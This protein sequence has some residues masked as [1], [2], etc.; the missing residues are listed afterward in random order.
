[1]AAKDSN[2]R[3]PAL[4]QGMT[5]FDWSDVQLFL[6]IAHVGSLRGASQ[7]A[8]LSV[9]SMRR[10]LQQLEKQ[11]GGRLFVRSTSGVQ[12]TEAGERLMAAS[13]NMRAG[14]LDVAG[15]ISRTKLDRT[16][17]MVIGVCEGLAS[18]WLQDRLIELRALRPDLQVEL[19][20]QV[21]PFNVYAMEVDLS[22]HLAPPDHANLMV[23]RLAHIHEQYFAG[24][25]FLDRNG[26]PS[27]PQDIANFDAVRRTGAAAMP[28]PPAA[29]KH[30]RASRPGAIIVDSTAAQVRAI[31]NDLGIGLL[32]TYVSLSGHNL[33]PLLNHAHWRRAVYLTYRKDLAEQNHVRAVI[34]WLKKMFDSRRCPWFGDLYVPPDHFSGDG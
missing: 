3:V 11:M 17:R 24:A 10:R 31:S 21:A 12:L 20:C 16:Q 29:D 23:S 1:M 5:R 25:A 9:N 19:R 14:A 22:V 8:S 33:V 34:N 7:R 4:E 18:Y 6:L 32:P 27:G 26:W 13:S 28:V 15:E 30:R 2:N